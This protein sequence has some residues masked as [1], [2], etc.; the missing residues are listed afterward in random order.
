MSEN[1]KI[2]EAI[3]LLQ[4]LKRTTSRRWKT[5]PSSSKTISNFLTASRR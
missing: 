3:T 5:T 1:E 2:D 4:E